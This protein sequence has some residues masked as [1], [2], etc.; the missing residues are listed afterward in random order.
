MNETYKPMTILEFHSHV[1][2]RYDAG[3]ITKNSRDYQL[4]Q[5]NNYV[6]LDGKVYVHVSEIH[7]LEKHEN[8]SNS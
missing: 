2:R 7:E 8:N 3:L 4:E 5:Y 6:N 1:Q